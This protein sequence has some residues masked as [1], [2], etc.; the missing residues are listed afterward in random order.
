MKKY[1]ITHVRYFEEQVFPDTSTAVVAFSFEKVDGPNDVQ[2]VPWERLPGGE[3]RTFT[4]RASEKWIIGGDIYDITTNPG[5]NI[6]RYIEGQEPKGLTGLTLHALD[7]SM[8]YAPEEVYRGKLTSRTYATLCIQGVALTE[9]AQREIA[10]R[11]NKYVAEK[12]KDTWS[13]F[14]PQYREFARKRM[15]F[16]LAH[17]IVHKIIRDMNLL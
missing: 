8:K 15:P 4:M 14:L 3:T 5:V 6:T 13:L 9:Q 7:C 17:V 2:Q 1:K 12:R 11:F 16:E 10:A